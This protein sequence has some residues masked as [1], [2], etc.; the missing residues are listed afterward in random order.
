MTAPADLLKM[1]PDKPTKDP[2]RGAANKRTPPIP[3]EKW[4]E[5][6]PMLQQLREKKMPVRELMKHMKSNYGFEAT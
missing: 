5:V 2:F 4:E 6:K 3:D 1:V